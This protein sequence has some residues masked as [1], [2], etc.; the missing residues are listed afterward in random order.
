[1][2]V[3]NRLSPEEWAARLNREMERV[4]ATPERFDPCVQQWARFRRTWLA[5]SGSLF[6]EPAALAEVA[7]SEGL[8]GPS[9]GPA[10][11]GGPDRAGCLA[12][13]GKT[14]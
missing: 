8:T 4:L 7:D 5:E 13:R 3:R 14:W 12:A 1:M 2:R 6:R 9:R 11:A 10:R